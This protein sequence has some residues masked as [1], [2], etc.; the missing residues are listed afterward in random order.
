MVAGTTGTGGRE[1][2]RNGRTLETSK[3]ALSDKPQQGRTFSSFQNNSTTQGPSIQSESV[4][5]TLI[6]TPT[7]GVDK[8]SSN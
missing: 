5:A 7:V 1:H 8:E 6:G 3:P 4:G 2:I